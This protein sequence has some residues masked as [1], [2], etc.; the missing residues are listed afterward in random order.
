LSF[1]RAV[2]SSRLERLNFIFGFNAER[3]LRTMPILIV[4][5]NSLCM[6]TR[7]RADFDTHLPHSGGHVRLR[8]NRTSGDNGDMCEIVL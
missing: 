6:E 8:F 1:F 5:R 4:M 2:I 7:R 3:F